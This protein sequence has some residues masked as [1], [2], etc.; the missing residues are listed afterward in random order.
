M[1]KR[2]HPMVMGLKVFL[3]ITGLA[4]LGFMAYDFK[5]HKECDLHFFTTYVAFI[6]TA[7]SILGATGKLCYEIYKREDCFK[8]EESDSEIEPR[9]DEE[10]GI[11]RYSEQP[12]M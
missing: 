7:I 2:L 11:R 3:T 9:S 8:K 10:E 12:G 4:G 5:Q 6:T 1:P